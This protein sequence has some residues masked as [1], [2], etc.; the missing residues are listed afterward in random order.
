[1]RPCSRWNPAGRPCSSSATISPSRSSGARSRAAAPSQRPDDRRELRRLLVAEAGP[2]PDCRRR[3][4]PGASSTRPGC[5]RTSARR[6]APRR[7]RRHRPASPA[8]AGRD[9]QVW[10]Q[11]GGGMTVHSGSGSEATEPGSAVRRSMAGSPRTPSR[12]LAPGSRHAASGRDRTA[13]LEHRAGPGLS[14]PIRNRDPDRRPA[15]RRTPSAWR[16]RAI[17]A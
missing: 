16:L 4:A 14:G 1:M 11:A 10:R 13:L 6:R 12:H 15:E 5:R 3:S 8:S 17:H 7:Q 9:R 2:D